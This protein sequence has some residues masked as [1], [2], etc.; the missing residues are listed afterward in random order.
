MNA[1]AK[2]E[3]KDVAVATPAYLLQMAVQQGADLDKLEKLMGLQERWE[4]NE[5]RKAFVS[6][7]TAFKAEPLSISK[8]KLVGYEGKDGKEVGYRHATLDAVVDVATGALSKHGLT[9]RWNVTQED[10]KITV[11]CVLTHEQGHSERIAMSAPPDDSGKKNRIQQ[12]A[13]TVTYLERYTLLA[14]TGL[15]A[16]DQDND[17]AAPKPFETITEKQVQEITDWIADTGSDMTKFCDAFKVSAIAEL[18]ARDYA[19]AIAAFKAKAKK[20]SHE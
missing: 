13:S 3:T 1:V 12:I 4:A 10:H 11:E 15:A 14:I 16:K 19:R 20:A 18:P 6:A 5:A 2:I 7:L 9:H 8:N 17:G